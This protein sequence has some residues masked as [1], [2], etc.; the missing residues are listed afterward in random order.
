MK[1]G[2]FF[3]FFFGGGGGVGS[4]LRVN[5]EAKVKVKSLFKHGVSFRK[6]GSWSRNPTET[7]QEHPLSP[8]D[9]RTRA[10]HTISD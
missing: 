2:M 10:N 5:S 6:E 3:F 4:I 8:W 9:N 1:T 7:L